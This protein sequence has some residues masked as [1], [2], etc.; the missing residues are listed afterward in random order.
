MS[1]AKLD[2]RFPDHPKVVGAGGDAAWLHV[3]ALCYAAGQLTDGFIPESVVPRLSDRRNPMRLAAKLIAVG[4]WEPSEGG[5]QIHDYLEWNPSAEMVRQ[6][7][8]EVHET[9][10]RAGKL[11]AAKRWQ[12]PSQVDGSADG[13]SDGKPI[14]PSA[15]ALPLTADS[16]T[17]APS[18]SRPDP[19]PIPREEKQSAATPLRAHDPVVAELHDRIRSRPIFDELPALR[20][21]DEGAGWMQNKGL[22]LEWVL[23]AIDQAATKC[24]DGTTYHEKHRMLVGFMHAAKKPRAPEPDQVDPTSLL[25]S[26]PDTPDE[27]RQ[28]TAEEVAKRMAKMTADAAAFDARMKIRNGE[29]KRSGGES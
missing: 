29:S 5:Y 11:G 24:P 4:L 23:E 28:L 17:M 16:K 9:K 15:I 25:A 1:W 6:K 21:A 26:R 3:C 13:T 14:A 20:I 2:D 27:S 8:A 12:S 7:R 19:V 18:R 22:K 10:S